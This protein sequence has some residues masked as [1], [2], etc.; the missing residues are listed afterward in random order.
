M[1]DSTRAMASHFV[2]R[3]G[4]KRMA[5][6]AFNEALQLFDAVGSRTGARRM[7]SLVFLPSLTDDIPVEDEDFLKWLQ[8]HPE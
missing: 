1:R 5:I 7:L 2:Q 4:S 3:F 8:S 6:G